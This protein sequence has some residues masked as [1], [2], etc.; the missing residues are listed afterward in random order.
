[1]KKSGNVIQE[2]SFA[3][4]LTIIELYNELK[5]RK[6]FDILKQL[7]RAGSSIG[8]NVEERIAAYSKKDSMHKKSIASNEGRE[9]SYWFRLLKAG[10]LVEVPDQYFS[11]IKEINSILTSIVKT[12][13]ESM[14]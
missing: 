11:D 8:A 9:T 14:K 6:E 1:M 5:A 4:T 3:F 13:S 10:G 7:L 12:T 2:N